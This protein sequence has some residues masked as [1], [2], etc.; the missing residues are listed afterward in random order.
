[1]LTVGALNPLATLLNARFEEIRSE[2]ASV[3]QGDDG[4]AMLEWT[5]RGRLAGGAPVT[6]SGVSVLELRDGRVRRFRAYFDTAQLAAP[7]EP[8]G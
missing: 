6:Y 4:T 1:M 2:F 5:S 3:V 8:R 7:A